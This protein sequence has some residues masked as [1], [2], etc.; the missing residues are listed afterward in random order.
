MMPREEI[1]GKVRILKTFSKEKNKQV[2]GGEVVSGKIIE[3]KI[4]KIKRRES[5]I[6]EGKILE[7]QQDKVKT[8]EVNEGSQFGSM[9]ESKIE[10]IKG[11]ELE[12]IEKIK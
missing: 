4:F 6:G 3:G 11:D 12:I 9:T 8:K 1:R 2:L 5:E 7:L 10:I